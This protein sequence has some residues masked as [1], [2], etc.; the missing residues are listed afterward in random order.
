MDEAEYDQGCEE[1]YLLK[2]D[3]PSVDR[4]SR[5]LFWLLFHLAR[6]EPTKVRSALEG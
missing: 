3:S 1:I 5:C 4:K 2:F 6:K